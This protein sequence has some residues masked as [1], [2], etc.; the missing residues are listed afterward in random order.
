MLQRNILNSSTV[1]QINAW[2][3]VCF[4]GYNSC[5]GVR[6]YLSSVFISN[7]NTFPQAWVVGQPMP[8]LTHSGASNKWR[9]VE[10]GKYLNYYRVRQWRERSHFDSVFVEM[11]GRFR[12]SL[13]FPRIVLSL[14]LAKPRYHSSS[15]ILCLTFHMDS[16]G[17]TAFVEQHGIPSIFF[18]FWCD[19]AWKCKSLTFF[20]V[21]FL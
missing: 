20:K 19:K 13:I 3:Q 15:Q 2:N 5:D 17:C 21:M 18:Y 10:I 8:S 4:T 7:V 11:F 1:G 6:F 9:I 16:W 12:F 14:F